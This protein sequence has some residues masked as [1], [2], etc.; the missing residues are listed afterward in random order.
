MSTRAV[1]VNRK[2]FRA[3]RLLKIMFKYCFTTTGG[4]QSAHKIR[5]AARRLCTD[6]SSEIPTF[7]YLLM[8]KSLELWKLF[9]QNL[10][11]NNR[12]R[13]SMIT[14]R[15]RGN[16]MTSFRSRAPFLH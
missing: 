3:S 14:Y 13:F 1:G 5:D 7:I 9:N 16:T 10:K 4:M 6:N 11:K 2:Y 15:F 8:L 12:F